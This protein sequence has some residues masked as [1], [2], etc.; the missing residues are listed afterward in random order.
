[1]LRNN[2]AV[3]STA[4]MIFMDMLLS[5]REL[6]AIS[7]EAMAVRPRLHC[8][9]MRSCAVGHLTCASSRNVPAQSMQPTLFELVINTGT[10]KALGLTITLDLQAAADEV[11]G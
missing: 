4:P 7:F 8:D 6:N 11:I 2:V 3:A 9:K 10:A 1:V 5:P